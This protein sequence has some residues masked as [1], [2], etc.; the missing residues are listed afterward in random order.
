MFVG[1]V[2]LA[3][4]LRAARLI[5]PLAARAWPGGCW[6]RRSP[7]PSRFSARPGFFGWLRASLGDLA[8][9]RAVGYFVAKVPLTIF[10]V[11]FALS[12]WVEAL[13]S[14]AAPLTGSTG[15]VRFGA[16]GRLFGPDYY[17]GPAPRLATHAGVFLSGVVLLFVAPWTMRLVVY[18]DRRM[19]HLLLGP[20]ASASRLRS[21]EESRSKTLDAATETLRRIER[22]LH[23]GTQAQ[24]VALAMRLG[25]AKE[26]LDHLAAEDQTADMAAI[27]RL[28]DEAHR[29]AKEA[30]T[31]LRDLARGIHPPALDTGLEN[32]L[33]TLAARSSGTHRRGGGD[34][35]SAQPAPSRPSATSAPPSC[36]P[37]SP[38]TPRP[39]GPSSSCAQHGPWLRIV[40]RD[41]GRGGAAVNRNGASSS[42]LA[43][44]ADRV[45]AVDGHLSIAS[46]AGGPTA[47]TVD[48]PSTLVSMAS[49]DAHN[50]R[51]RRG[52]RH[53]ARRIGPASHRQGLRRDPGRRAMPSAL[54][55]RWREDPPDVAVVDIRMPPSFTDEGLRAALALRRNHPGVGI[56]VFS[57]YVETR[58][59]AELLAGGAAGIGYLLKDRVADVTDFVE[60]LVRVASGGTA[61][62]PEVV[63]QLMGASRRTDTLA[64]LSGREREV[65]AFMAEGRTNSAIAAS[66]I[67]S[68]GA[69]EKHVANIFSKLD[70][71][72]TPADH[73]RVLAVLRYLEG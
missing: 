61:L 37:M 36:S 49:A 52:F 42:G 55:R 7:N 66:L 34:P 4:G 62:D 28:V 10:G 29:G 72:A 18:L 47:V 33:A 59:A 12:V 70:L 1:I 11:W 73:R 51:D 21:L 19:M 27:R 3:G 45:G 39:P 25:Q 9:W 60:A 6:A 2:I 65:L 44:L 64:G 53:P 50:R 58:Y 40:V 68:E 48:L 71:P 35:D 5:R 69:V 38:S 22:N 30:I 57:Q 14:V 13:F 43:G 41:N 24:L 16:F 23:D 32:A 56:L 31:D 67:I 26:K 17:G 15:P 20:D 63:T 54:S 46:P 8:A